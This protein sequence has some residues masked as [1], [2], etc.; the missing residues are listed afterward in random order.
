MAPRGVPPGGVVI[1]PGDLVTFSGGGEG[2]EVMCWDRPLG[3]AD[4]RVAVWVLVGTLGILLEER[5]G[6]WGRLGWRSY[7]VGEGRVVWVEP[8]RDWMIRP[9]TP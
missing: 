5:P 6:R 8:G 3:G 9:L 4:D 2:G 7:L 1:S